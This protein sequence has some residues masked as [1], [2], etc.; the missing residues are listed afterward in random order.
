MKRSNRLILVLMAVLLL[1]VLAGGPVAAGT[2][3]A[4]AAPQVG[5]VDLW[6][7]PSGLLAHPFV[8]GASGSGG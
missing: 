3:P 7:C 2:A 4:A 6:D 8:G 5:S 1:L